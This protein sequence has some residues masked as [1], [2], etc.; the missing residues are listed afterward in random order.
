MQGLSA[1]SLQLDVLQ[2]S[3]EASPAAACSL[4]SDLH[5]G[6]CC[7]GGVCSPRKSLLSSCSPCS[8]LTP[9]S[10]GRP[11]AADPGLR[12]ASLH[13]TCLKLI[14]DLDLVLTVYYCHGPQGYACLLEVGS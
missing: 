12:S 14:W 5:T 9:L 11:L 10:S 2:S 3:S 4:H 8:R 7:C 6:V 13:P 1:P